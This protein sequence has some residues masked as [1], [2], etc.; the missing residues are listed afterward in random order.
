MADQDKDQKPSTI[1]DLVKQLSNQPPPNLPGVKVPAA[2]I[3]RSV[4]PQGPVPS[5]QREGN[6]GTGTP[7]PPIPP[8]PQPTSPMPP[9]PSPV[10]EY[11]SSIRTMGEDITSLKSGQKPSGVDVPRRVAP[12]AP[13]ASLPGAPAAPAPTGPMSSIGLGKT[14]K[15]GLLPG[16][17]KPAVPSVFAGSSRGACAYWSC[18]LYRTWKDRKNRIITGITQTGSPLPRQAWADS[19]PWTSR[20]NGASA[21]PARS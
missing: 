5:P 20:K 1:D 16:L 6:I 8:R 2:E 18:V 17:P 14:E 9:K 15:T 13:K 10:Q 7:T 4:K 11:R 3:D 21:S 19:R 12:E